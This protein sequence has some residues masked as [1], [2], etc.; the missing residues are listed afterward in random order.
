MSSSAYSQLFSTFRKKFSL[1]RGKVVNWYPGHMMKGMLQIQAKMKKI[2]CIV[3]IHDARI[4]FSGRDFKLREI[5]KLRPHILL[6]NKSDLID[7]NES[8][9]K[10][11]TKKLTEQDVNTVFFTHL[12][13]DH[14]YKLL[15][16]TILPTAVEL[17]NSNPR[18]NREGIDS[19]NLLVLGVPNVGKSTFINS[20]RSASLRKGGKATTVG[21]KAGVT[22]SV[23]S[24]IKVSEN[25]IS[26]VIDTPG[27][28]PPKIPTI[29]VGMRLAACACLPDAQ[30]GFVDIADYI[31]FHLNKT[32]NFKY[33]QYFELDTPCDVINDV[34]Y[35]IALKKRKIM[36]TKDIATGKEVYLPNFDEAA[37]ILIS[38]FREG[39]LGPI[40]L[41][42]NKLDDDF[43]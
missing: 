35:K 6:L 21:A 11:V 5:I 3:E 9:K 36:K 37:K 30:V 29:D 33:V 32:R 20:L 43:R 15:K 23:L 16:Q 8:Q 34:L 38:S 10:A 40:F 25:P 22:K 17:I 12:K 41:D 42:Y 2:D 27:I 4:P 28:M 26:Y 31:L 7:L 13:T 14:S 19:Y 24:K 1:S 39:R 18:Y